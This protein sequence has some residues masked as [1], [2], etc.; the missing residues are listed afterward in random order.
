[1]NI[2]LLQSWSVQVETALQKSRCL[3]FPYL[4]FYFIQLEMFGMGFFAVMLPF[5]RNGLSNFDQIFFY[6]LNLHLIAFF[7]WEN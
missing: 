4:L 5:L 2:Q 6:I 1:M 3:G 7:V